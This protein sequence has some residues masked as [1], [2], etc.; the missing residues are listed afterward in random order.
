MP[1]KDDIFTTVAVRMVDVVRYRL[2]VGL[3]TRGTSE[4]SSTAEPEDGM[5]CSPAGQEQLRA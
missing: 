3:Q 4:Y 1:L 2:S 5:D